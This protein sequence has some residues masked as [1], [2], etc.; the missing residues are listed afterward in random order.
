MVGLWGAELEW[1]TYDWKTSTL[2]TQVQKCPEDTEPCITLDGYRLVTV[3][4]L[5]VKECERMTDY[6]ALCSIKQSRKAFFQYTSFTV[7]TS[8]LVVDDY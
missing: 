8:N 7:S 3:E 1:S 6:K 4:Q 5:L 2:P